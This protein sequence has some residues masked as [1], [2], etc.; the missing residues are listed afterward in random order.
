MRVVLRRDR[1]RRNVNLMCGSRLPLPHYALVDRVDLVTQ[2]VV[3]RAASLTERL[4]L[5][6][7][8]NYLANG[9]RHSPPPLTSSAI[10]PCLR[11]AMHARQRS[12]SARVIIDLNGCTLPVF[13]V[14][15]QLHLISR[16]KPG[17]AFD[18]LTETDDPE[19]VRFIEASCLCRIIDRRFTLSGIQRAL[20]FPRVIFNNPRDRF[21]SQE[22]EIIRLMAQGLTLRNIAAQQQRPYHRIIY[23]LARILALLKI[24]KRQQFIR[25]LQRISE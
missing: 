10:F 16:Q 5:V 9:I 4:I 24:K 6:T 20:A 3:I 8:D 18:L 13:D 25:L 23:R 15:H 1:R 21:I 19:I 11:E 2:P 14:L 22:W 17:L 7:H 12:D